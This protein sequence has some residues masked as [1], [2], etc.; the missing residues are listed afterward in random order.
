MKPRQKLGKLS[1]QLLTRIRQKV[2][3]LSISRYEEF[4]QRQQSQLNDL[5]SQSH[6]K[7]QSFTSKIFQT[8]KFFVD[9]SKTTKKSESEKKAIVKTESS[10]LKQQPTQI[11]I[12]FGIEKLQYSDGRTRFK[13]INNE[14]NIS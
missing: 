11:A 14:K 7:F 5:K 1:A 3:K 12:A 8:K 4:S 13:K 2:A 9:K 6:Y 10:N